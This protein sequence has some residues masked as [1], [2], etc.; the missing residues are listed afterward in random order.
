[1]FTVVV[2]TI[3]KV[4]LFITL[5]IMVGFNCSIAGVVI[6]IDGIKG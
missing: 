4:D 1:M 6:V 3:T 5:V 2:A